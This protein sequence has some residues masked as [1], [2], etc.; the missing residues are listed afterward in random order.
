M[1]YA[2]VLD[3]KRISA[4]EMPDDLPPGQAMRLANDPVFPASRHPE[5]ILQPFEPGAGCY[6]LG[7]GT[8]GLAWHAPGS[9]PHFTGEVVKQWRYPEWIRSRVLV[10]VLYKFT[11]YRRSGLWAPSHTADHSPQR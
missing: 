1:T 2:Q 4:H 8:A 9:H 10:P 3:L 5:G 11:L 7:S 6:L